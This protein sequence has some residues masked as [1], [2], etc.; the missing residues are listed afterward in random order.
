MPAIAPDDRGCEARAPGEGE[1]PSPEP[2][3][4]VDPEVD[5]GSELRG[6]VEEIPGPTEDWL[7]TPPLDDVAGPVLGA[8]EFAEESPAAGEFALVA[9]LGSVAEFDWSDVAGGEARRMLPAGMPLDELVSTLLCG[10]V[11]GRLLSGLP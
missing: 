10:V 1:D 3:P 4:V 11:D 8:P 2:S 5:G 7:E 9:E 6:L